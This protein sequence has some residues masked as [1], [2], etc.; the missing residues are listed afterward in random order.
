[1]ERGES[2]DIASVEV[3]FVVLEQSNG[4]L[5]VPVD[6]GVEE[7]IS[8]QLPHSRSRHLI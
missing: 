6:D 8:P 4:V 2:V 1:M 7:Q 3:D 5:R